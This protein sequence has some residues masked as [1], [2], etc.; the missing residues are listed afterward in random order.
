MKSILFLMAA[1]LMPAFSSVCVRAEEETS[2]MDIK[3]NRQAVRRLVFDQDQSISL[4]TLNPAKIVKR[5]IEY[6]TIALSD[7][8]TVYS[9]RIL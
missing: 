4:S 7:A 9:L 3:F 6:P 2:P 1:T 5:S 8:G